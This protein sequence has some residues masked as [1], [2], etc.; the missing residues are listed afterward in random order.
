VGL[1]VRD[2]VAKMIVIKDYSQMVGQVRQMTSWDIRC[3][4]QAAALG[5]NIKET[6]QWQTLE[7][8]VAVAVVRNHT[9]VQ[10]SQLHLMAMG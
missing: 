2:L 5:L 4:G 8:L 7:G 9:V 6:Q 1:V 3:I 10:D